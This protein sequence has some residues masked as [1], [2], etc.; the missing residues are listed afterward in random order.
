MGLLSGGLNNVNLR[1]PDEELALPLPS[2]MTAQ[3]NFEVAD[4]SCKD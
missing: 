2:V 4:G 1:Y 3:S